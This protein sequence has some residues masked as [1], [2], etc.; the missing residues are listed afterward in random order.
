MLEVI[1]FKS[2]KCKD[3]HTEDYH[4]SGTSLKYS[5]HPS[6]LFW[7]SFLCPHNPNHWCTA[8]ESSTVRLLCLCMLLIHSFI[9]SFTHTYPFH[10]ILKLDMNIKNVCSQNMS[11]KNSQSDLYSK[12]LHPE[13]WQANTRTPAL[14]SGIGCQEKLQRGKGLRKRPAVSGTDRSMKD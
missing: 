4:F 8:S 3:P 7:K 14:T 6:K 1:Y 12:E 13:L 9:R 10:Q 5:P 2:S 11:K